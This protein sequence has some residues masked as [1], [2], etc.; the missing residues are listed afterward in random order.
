VSGQLHGLV[1]L[2]QGKEPLELIEYE[3]GWAP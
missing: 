3:A 2:P 1:A